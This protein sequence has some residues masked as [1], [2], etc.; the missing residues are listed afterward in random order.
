MVLMR[1]LVELVIA[2]VVVAGLL[3]VTGINPVG[4]M[5]EATTALFDVVR[6]LAGGG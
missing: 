5:W 1:L 2:F 3:W 6:G 4:V